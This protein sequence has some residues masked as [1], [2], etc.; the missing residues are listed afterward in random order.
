MARVMSI[1]M[2]VFIFVP[3]VAPI[4]G[5]AIMHLAGWRAIFGSFLLLSAVGGLWFMMRQKET[6]PKAK[7]R[8][9][10]PAVL[11]QGMKMVFTTPSCIGYMVASGFR[12]RAFCSVSEHGSKSVSNHLSIG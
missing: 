7:R 12:V 5:Q 3:V 11:W 6:L 1:V 8:A 4:L 10:T 2:G 9:M